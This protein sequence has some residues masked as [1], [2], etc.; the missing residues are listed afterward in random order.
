MAKIRQRAQSQQNNTDATRVATA[1]QTRQGP[2]RSCHQHRHILQR[3][4]SG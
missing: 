4:A 2:A 3:G 1:L